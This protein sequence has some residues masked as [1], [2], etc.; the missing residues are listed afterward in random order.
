M[1]YD[2]YSRMIDCRS[3]MAQDGI[4]Y[5][6]KVNVRCVAVN[7]ASTMYT[8]PSF[9][10]SEILFHLSRMV[11][12]RTMVSQF[13]QDNAFRHGSM[14]TQLHFKVLFSLVRILVSI[15]TSLHR[16]SFSFARSRCILYG[17]YR[18][19]RRRR[20]QC[21]ACA[22]CGTTDLNCYYYV[23]TVYRTCFVHYNHKNRRCAHGKLM[24]F[25]FSTS[26]HRV[27]LL[28]PA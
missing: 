21:A 18:R 6:P 1:N 20:Q 13:A 7:H 17:I 10:V 16:P 9:F 19:C 15:L 26:I 4:G 14:I 22:R 12:P 8:M 23:C 24:H 2:T 27:R 3:A 25:F 11:R 28:R 5:H